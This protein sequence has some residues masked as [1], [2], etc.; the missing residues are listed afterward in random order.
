MD[1]GSGKLKHKLFLTEMENLQSTNY[2]N[3]SMQNSDDLLCYFGKENPSALRLSWIILAIF[4]SLFFSQ[5]KVREENKLSIDFSVALCTTVG[6]VQLSQIPG[7]EGETKVNLNCSPVSSDLGGTAALVF[8][9]DGRISIFPIQNGRIDFENEVPLLS[10]KS[11]ATENGEKIGEY[12]SVGRNLIM[13]D[14]LNREKADITFSTFIDRE[15]GILKLLSDSISQGIG[16]KLEKNKN[17]V[18]LSTHL[19]VKNLSNVIFPVFDIINLIL[20]RNMKIRDMS[21]ELFPFTLTKTKTKAKIK[22][23]L[24][25]LTEINDI[26]PPL[27]TV[28]PELNYVMFE[29]IIAQQNFYEFE[30]TDGKTQIPIFI[31]QLG[32]TLPV[33]V[34]AEAEEGKGEELTF[35]S[36]IDEFPNKLL[37]KK[38]FSAKISRYTFSEKD[39]ISKIKFN[40]PEDQTQNVDVELYS[41]KGGSYILASSG[42]VSSTTPYLDISIPQSIISESTYVK[43]SKKEEK[44]TKNG[45]REIITYEKYKLSDVPK[46]V[47]NVNFIPEELTYFDVVIPGERTGQPISFMWKIPEKIKIDDLG[48]IGVPPPECV[49]QD[50]RFT[51]V[52]KNCLSHH[53]ALFGEDEK[54]ESVLVWRIFG[55][56]EKDRV[57]LPDF[58]SP[59]FIYDIMERNPEI[60]IKKARLFFSVFSSDTILVLRKTLIFS[61]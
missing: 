41:L 51:Y 44:K 24:P 29:D 60:R 40:F 50:R 49:E 42:I 38:N 13:F 37:G 39:L 14:K 8:F 54:G 20:I 33:L 25:A 21:A 30:I 31:S 6:M 56:Y 2:N 10:I 53:I 34:K 7:E 23:S 59:E 9:T 19:G 22:I 12:E 58:T 45:I 57:K 28:F 4:F 61:D 47:Y 1:S 52:N 27:L 36:E 32:E 15:A 17:F 26:L 3:I 35:F 16:G 55:L 46:V 48:D 5:C 43:I 11:F 18:F